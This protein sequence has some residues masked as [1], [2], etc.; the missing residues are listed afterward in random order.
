MPAAPSVE[1]ISA[2][3]EDGSTVVETTGLA[4]AVARVLRPDAPELRWPASLVRTNTAEG[5]LTGT[6]TGQSEPLPLVLAAVR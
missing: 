5:V 3:F 2:R 6:W 1:D 4:L